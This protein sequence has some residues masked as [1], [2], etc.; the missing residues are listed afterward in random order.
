MSATGSR[1]STNSQ[2]RIKNSTVPTTNSISKWNDNND[3]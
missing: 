2:S 1:Y 3:E